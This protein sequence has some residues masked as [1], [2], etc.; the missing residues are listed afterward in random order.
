MLIRRVDWIAE[1]P[2]LRVSIAD[3]ANWTGSDNTAHHLTHRYNTVFPLL[4]K[5]FK[6]KL[7]FIIE[8]KRQDTLLMANKTSRTSL[9]VAKNGKMVIVAKQSRVNYN[10]LQVQRRCAI[11]SIIVELAAGSWI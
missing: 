3:L 6:N 9:L 7:I 5:Q 4:L 11:I 8:C 10:F 2:R 1:L